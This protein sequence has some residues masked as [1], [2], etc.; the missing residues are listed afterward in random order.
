MANYLITVE[1]QD[2]ADDHP[3]LCDRRESEECLAALIRGS[4]EWH[5]E[6]DTSW[7]NAQLRVGVPQLPYYIEV[8]TRDKCRCLARV[9]ADYDTCKEI[10]RSL[11]ESVGADS[12][13]I[14]R[15]DLLTAEQNDRF[16][17][18]LRDGPVPV[19]NWMDRPPELEDESPTPE[20][21]STALRVVSRDT[22]RGQ[23]S[24]SEEDKLAGSVRGS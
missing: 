3:I 24:A 11:R 19:S 5:A 20:L 16:E 7:G 8:G 12:S 15:Q 21:I 14:V 6:R 17:D 10:A 1:R 13:R 4:V 18:E 9:C 23:A 2:A 22:P